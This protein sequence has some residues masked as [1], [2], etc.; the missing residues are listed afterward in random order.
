MGNSVFNLT[1]EI[2]L[3]KNFMK[4]GSSTEGKI[5][6]LG[7]I[8]ISVFKIFNIITLYQFLCLFMFYTFWLNCSILYNTSAYSKIEKKI[9]K[10][11]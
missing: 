10:M 6:M 4:I 9:S 5:F 11:D 3:D 8:F 2:E 1:E 7:C